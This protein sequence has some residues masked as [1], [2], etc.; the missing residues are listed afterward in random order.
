M[1]FASL[2]LLACLVGIMLTLAASPLLVQPDWCLA[3]LLASLLARRMS[4]TWVLPA[5]V[6]HDIALYW[7]A[8]VT[9]P[10][11]ALIPPLLAYIDS[12]IGPGL[13][14]RVILLLAASMPL[15]WHGGG[16]MPWLL[17]V[18]LAI[19]LWYSLVHS[20]YVEPA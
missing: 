7:S 4:W 17:T 1:I 19:P 10:L 6:A 12:A 15:L 9:F 20:S 13:P 16:F 18:L 5:A 14:Q 11:I 8:L 2:I 3:L